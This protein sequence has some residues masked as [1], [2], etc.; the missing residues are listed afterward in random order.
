MVVS[1]IG[2]SPSGPG[3]LDSSRGDDSRD[4]VADRGGD[5]GVSVSL[6]KLED[7]LDDFSP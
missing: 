4:D 3:R 6:L 5:P 1:M 2:E 7:L